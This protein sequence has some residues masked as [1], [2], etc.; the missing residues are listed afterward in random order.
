LDYYLEDC[1]HEAIDNY[2]SRTRDIDYLT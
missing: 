1:K 2:K